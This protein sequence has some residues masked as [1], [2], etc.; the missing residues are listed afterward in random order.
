MKIKAIIFDFDDTLFM[1][2][3]TRI[4]AGIYW[5][6]H[7]YNRTI[8]KQDILK[9]WGKPFDEFMKAFLNGEDGLE[10]AKERYYSILHKFPNKTYEGVPA[11]LRRLAREYKLGMVSASS[12]KLILPEFK[13]SKIDPKLF[14]FIQAQEH[15]KVHKPD[16]KVF[17]PIL[18]SFSKLKIS[19]QETVYV[20]DS[21][22][23]LK[24][25]NG[26]GLKFIAIANNSEPVNFWNQQDCDYVEDIR[27]LP[28]KLKHL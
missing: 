27:D 25:A 15:S 6:K 14:Q 16:P 21:I 23:D 19:R 11:L 13:A 8:T 18:D 4:A 1:T 20:G 17:D 12:L 28:D 24:A 22:V 3:Q 2:R 26:A 9:Q 7:F 10:L 5:A